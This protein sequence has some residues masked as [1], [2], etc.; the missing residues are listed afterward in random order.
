VSG[1]FAPTHHS[2]TV[3]PGATRT[4]LNIRR[5]PAARQ[6]AQEQRIVA[7]VK[8]ILLE[9]KSCARAALDTPEGQIFSSR[10]PSNPADLTGPVL[11]DPSFASGQEV[12]A[13]SA[14]YP[15]LQACQKAAIDGFTRSPVAASVLP[16]LTA[17]SRRSDRQVEL[18]EGRKITWG[19]FNTARKEHAGE[20]QE[21]LIGAIKGVLVTVPPMGEPDIT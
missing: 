16:I 5:S 2:A 19:A 4:L 20:M 9:M 7:A 14:L 1:V 21:Q 10:S 12:E 13:V 15:R 6:T 11:S 17:A 3:Q 8:P 18:L